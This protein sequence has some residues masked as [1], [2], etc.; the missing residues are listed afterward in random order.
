MTET[1]EAKS[2]QATPPSFPMPRAC[3][4]RPP[5]QY[6]DLREREPVSRVVL[7]TGRV[8]WLVT[9][10][11]LARQLLA[12]QRVSVNRAH[13]GYPALTAATA[14]MGA[15]QVKGFLTWMDPPV[16]TEHKKMI[17]NE[18]TVA[19]VATMR[20]QVQR[21]VDEHI[22]EMIASGS[23]TDLVEALSLAVPSLVICDLLGVPYGDREEFQHRAATLD[24]RSTTPQAKMEAFTG[25]RGY[26]GKL[27][28][29]KSANP[30]DDLLSRLT[31]KYH[32]AGTYD[33]D[34]LAGLAVL[35]LTGGFET[36]ANM[37][38]LGVV[39]LIEHPAEREKVM[40]DSRCAANVV[41][42]LLRFFSIAETSTSRVIAEDIELGGVTLRAG[43][44]V[45][46][47][48]N[49]ADHDPAV[50][51]DPD[52]LDAGR[53]EA[54]RHLAFG[55]GIHQC[56]GQNLARLEL[57]VVYSTLF[58]RLPTLRLAVPFDELPFKRDT[59]FYG[60]HEVPV[61]W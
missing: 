45:I 22:D 12:D 13:P 2:A 47:S 60:V 3:P 33:H 28:D 23:P 49:A 19:R 10:H 32:Q 42:E 1:T 57:Q 48:S 18:F 27:V 44:G 16:H 4:F 59:N 52:R 9:R 25:L 50:F 20:P 35:L 11:D 21:I 38:S 46:I 55:Y 14:G 36:T 30:G 6:A 29:E 53:E 34:L 54:K 51:A 7:P 37:I 56:L 41:D 17:I 5:A 15:A 61:A 40:A 8:A 39:A 43:D 58:R 24:A 26:I 31:V